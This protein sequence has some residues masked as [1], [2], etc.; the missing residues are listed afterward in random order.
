MT[1][2]KIFYGTECDCLKDTKENVVDNFLRAFENI[3]LNIS[4]DDFKSLYELEIKPRNN[5]CEEICSNRGVSVSKIDDSN[6]EFIIKH[7]VKTFVFAPKIKKNFVVMFS[8]KKYSG[9]LKRTGN[10]KSRN[11][12]HYE[13]YK[14]DE[15]T[16][17][18]IIEKEVIKL[19]DYVSN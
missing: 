1:F 6:K 13:F 18:H 19:K 8:F 4:D 5:N 10:C 2:E 7:F 12:Y 14:S 11:P 9:K 15:F 16:L 3:D 17:Q